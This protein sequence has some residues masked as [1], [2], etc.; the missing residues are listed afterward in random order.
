MIEY[1]GSFRFPKFD[2][3]A[4]GDLAFHIDDADR[5]YRASY[6]WTVYNDEQLPWAEAYW[7]RF[8][9]RFVK[10]LPP[11]LREPGEGR[12]GIN[13]GTFN[14]VYQKAWMRAGCGGR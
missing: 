1:G 3:Q 10:L 14:G 12:R 7:D 13:L 2:V 4:L 5:V 11:R 8:I 9:E 6:D